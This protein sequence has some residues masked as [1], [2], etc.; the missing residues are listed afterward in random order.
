MKDKEEI[1]NYA[2]ILLRRYER[3][4]DMYP[5]LNDSKRLRLGRIMDLILGKLEGFKFVLDI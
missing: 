4:R 1:Q 2:N 5:K 3:L